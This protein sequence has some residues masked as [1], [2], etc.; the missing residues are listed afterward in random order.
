MKKNKTK[1][2]TTVH[3]DWDLKIE[4]SEALNDKYISQCVSKE[5]AFFNRA[6][7]ELLDKLRR[8]KIKS[9]EVKQK[10]KK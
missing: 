4:I 6:G 7:R 9:N 1:R 10:C 5:K 8:Q 3:V 2:A